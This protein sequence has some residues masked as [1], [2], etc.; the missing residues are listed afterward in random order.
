MIVSPRDVPIDLE[1]VGHVAGSREIEIRARVTGIVQKRLYDEGAPVK[2]GQ[3]LFLLDQAP[4]RARLALAEAQLAQ[5]QARAKQAARD[6]K[7]I[8]PLAAAQA[9]SRKE[10][11][12]AASALDLALASVKAAEAQVDQA[13][14]DLGYTE[15]RAPLDGIVGRALKVEGS[16]AD[17]SGDNLLAT[18]A[19]IDPAYVVYGV[20]ETERMRLDHEIATRKLM[21]PA[22]GFT[23][24]VRLSDDQLLERTG[25][26]EFRDYRADPAT[27]T[28]AARA[29]VPNPD[30]RLAPGQFVRVMLQGAMRPQ[31]LVVP[32]RAVLDNP[33]GKFVY[34]VGSGANGVAIA[35]PRPVQVG[36]W[37]RLDGELANG[38]IIRDGLKPGDRVVVDGVAR[39]FFPGAP[40]NPDAP[41]TAEP[42]TAAGKSPG[43][44]DR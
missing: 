30:G 2:T 11:D 37:V 25:R 9:A 26:V 12:D 24:R 38:W 35:E 23:V 22:N 17:A 32:Q 10:A 44:G 33:S 41:K 6:D 15:I 18:L 1:Y 3:P 40:I 43:S 27:G 31:A 42:K 29:I 14:L 36:E 34:V 5:A 7:R 16:L 20:G 39:I 28:F 21:V 13:R 19:Q 4:F 8:R